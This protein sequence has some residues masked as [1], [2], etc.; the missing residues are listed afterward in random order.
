MSFKSELLS[1]ATT[2][3]TGSTIS[4][5]GQLARSFQ[6]VVTGTGAVSATVLIEVSNDGT[7]WVTLAT[8]SPSGT[9]SATDGAAV[10]VVAWSYVRARITAISG[11]SAAVTVGM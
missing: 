3:V 10:Q 2:T 6:A 7:N 4:L 9:T 1:G 11:T 8:L 5:S